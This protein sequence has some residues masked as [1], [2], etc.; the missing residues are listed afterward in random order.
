M[1]RYFVRLCSGAL[2]GAFMATLWPPLG[3]AQERPLGDERNPVASN[4]LVAQ[5]LRSDRAK[6]R[7]SRNERNMPVQARDRLPAVVNELGGTQG[8]ATLDL[9]KICIDWFVSWVEDEDGNALPGTVELSC[10]D[11]TIPLA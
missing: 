8:R 1:T 11:T 4:V 2:L 3:Q 5:A 9:D 7:E 10:D 6:R